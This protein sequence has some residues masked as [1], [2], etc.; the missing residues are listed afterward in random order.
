MSKAIG[1]LLLL[2]FSFAPSFLR[3][4]PRS[5]RTR[6]RASGAT[7]TVLDALKEFD[8]KF[9]EPFELLGLDDPECPK[10]EIR[11]AFRKVARVEHPDVSDKEDAEERFRRI[12]L[13]YELL[14]DDGGR[15]MLL[16]AGGFWVLE[17]D[18]LRDGLL[19]GLVGVGE[20]CR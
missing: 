6:L 5:C 4:F 19:L 15:A 7:Q 2:L 8:G 20:G 11:A 1:C 10:P 9:E 16:E 3:P 14:I 13:A 12:S 17:V 18:G